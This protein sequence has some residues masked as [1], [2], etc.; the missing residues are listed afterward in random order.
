[1]T[2]VREGRDSGGRREPRSLGVS[3]TALRVGVD[4]TRAASRRAATQGR[5][6]P[7]TKT[8]E[9][10]DFRQQPSLNKP[11]ILELAKGQYLDAAENVLLIGSSGVGKTHLAIALGLAA[12]RTPPSAAIWLISSRHLDGPFSWT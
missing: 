12:S 4:R 9:E 2:R 8:L 3:P 1:M 6:F 11:L 7:A 10:F 5:Q